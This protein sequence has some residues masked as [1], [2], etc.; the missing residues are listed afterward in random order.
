MPARLINLG[1]GWRTSA[2]CR[3]SDLAFGTHAPNTLGLHHDEV[4]RP[5]DTGAGRLNPEQRTPSVGLL[6]ARPSDW[7]ARR[8]NRSLC[9][10]SVSLRPLWRSAVRIVGTPEIRDATSVHAAQLSAAR[11]A[12]LRDR[13]TRKP[14]CSLRTTK[15]RRVVPSPTSAA[16]VVT[17]RRRCRC[18]RRGSTPRRASRTRPAPSP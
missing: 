15:R 1:E 9:A 5:R 2:R 3:P 7:I 14:A 12:H 4:A 11:A 16:T 8:S 13:I 10:T 18:R 6:C 17:S